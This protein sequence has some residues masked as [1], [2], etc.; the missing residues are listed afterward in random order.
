MNGVAQKQTDQLTL[1]LFP[2]K[3]E[4]TEETRVCENRGGPD[5][6]SGEIGVQA[7]SGF[8]FSIPLG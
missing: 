1:I 5:S 3:T 6:L 2:L 8:P 7:K 4:M